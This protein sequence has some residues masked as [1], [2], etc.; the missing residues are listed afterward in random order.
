MESLIRTIN[1]LQTGIFLGIDLPQISVVRGQSASKSS[2][3]ENFVGKDFLPRGAVTVTRRPLI[4]QLIHSNEEYGE[5]LHLQGKKFIDFDEIRKEIEAETDRLTGSNR[6]TSPIPINLRI[7]SPQ[8]LNLTLIDL[9]VLT[10]V[11]VDDQPKDIEKQ[12]R[13]MILSL[14]SKDSCLILAVTS[15]NQDLAKE[16]HPEELRTIGDLTKSYNQLCIQDIFKPFISP[17]SSMIENPTR[18]ASATKSKL[19]LKKKHTSQVLL[20]EVLFFFVHHK[21]HLRKLT[22]GLSTSKTKDVKKNIKKLQKS[23]DK[24]SMP[25]NT[26]IS[27]E[28]PENNIQ[29]CICSQ[30]S[31]ESAK[32]VLNPCHHSNFHEKCLTKWLSQFDECPSC[33]REV[34]CIVYKQR[35]NDENCIDH[36]FYEEASNDEIQNCLISE[37][38]TEQYIASQK[39]KAHK[40]GVTSQEFHAEQFIEAKF[41][42]KRKR[43]NDVLSNPVLFCCPFSCLLPEVASSL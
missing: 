24:E 33:E 2:V 31:S 18:I 28:S 3:L 34:S 41:D 15:G 36:L 35:N 42:L 11:P 5:F 39:I 6:G 9:P 38:V 13:E 7:Y 12:V 4:L 8:V 40:L 23:L 14:I 26:S 22:C 19:T 30:R 17:K 43:R 16:V 37:A 20:S 29:C 25:V 27:N 21:L 1:E 32:I 10:K